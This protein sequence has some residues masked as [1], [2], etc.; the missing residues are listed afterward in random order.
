M[1]DAA[2]PA[3]P[4]V[5]GAPAEASAPVPAADAAPAAVAITFE[6]QPDGRTEVLSLPLSTPVSDALSALTTQLGAAPDALESVTLGGEYGGES[7]R[8]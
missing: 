2:E 1:A 6:I 5:E 7:S 4:A 8:W 3:A